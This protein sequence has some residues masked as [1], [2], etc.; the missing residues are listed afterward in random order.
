MIEFNSKLVAFKNKNINENWLNSIAKI[1]LK[2]I[3]YIS[4]QI[5]DKIFHYVGEEY[6]NLLSF[7]Y[8]LNPNCKS[9]LKIECEIEEKSNEHLN[10]LDFLKWKVFNLQ[11]VNS[12]SKRCLRS[13]KKVDIESSLN[14]SVIS[15]LLKSNL[16]ID[17]LKLV[18]KKWFENQR[19]KEF[20]K[21]IKTLQNVEN[22][23]IKL[24]VSEEQR[25]S[26]R[27]IIFY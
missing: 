14:P 23:E 17:S 13:L 16:F 6:S 4:L 8:K 20:I 11:V 7:I 25:N 26:N 1:K 24:P 18:F 10:H 21:F 19:D 3:S 27:I 5:N 9:A 12:L 2:N 22:V 15:C